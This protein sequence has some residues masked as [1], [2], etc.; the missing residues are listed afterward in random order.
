M[1][2]WINGIFITSI[3]LSSGRMGKAKRAH[4]FHEAGQWQN[5]EDGRQIDFR[6]NDREKKS[7]PS[8]RDRVLQFHEAEQ[9]QSFE[10]RRQSRSVGDRGRMG[11]AKRAHQFHEAG[12]WQSFEDGRQ[13]DFRENDREKNLSPRS[14]SCPSMP[15]NFLFF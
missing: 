5:F 9:W 7:V 13:I 2:G 10:D 3:P 11:K 1:V 8:D 6:E 14:G 4:Q 15:L 12:Q